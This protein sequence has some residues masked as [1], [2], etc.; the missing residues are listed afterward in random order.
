[1][2]VNKNALIRYKIL[3]RCF[4]NP[5]KRYFIEDLVEECNKQLMEIDPN[6]KGIQKRQLFEDIKYMESAEGWSAE[7]EKVAF[8]KKK[9]YRYADKNFSINNQPLNAA[10]IEQLHSA[11]D[12]ISR[13]KGMPQFEWINEFTPKLEQAFTLD[14]HV[15][16]IIS[17][18][19]NEYLKGV[20]Y[21][22][23]LFHA[24]L[25]KKVLHITYQPFTSGT[26]R[27]FVIHPYYLKQ[28]NN[29]WFLFGHNE[30]M[31]KLTNLALDRITLIEEQNSIYH[32]NDEYDFNEYF[33]DIIGV[34]KPDDGVVEKVILKFS[35]LSLPYILSKPLH[36]SQKSIR[37]EGEQ[38][39]SIEVMIN[40]E[41]ESLLLSFGDRVS[42]S[43][44]Q[45]LQDKIKM[46]LQ[47]AIEQYPTIKD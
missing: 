26:P 10:E 5:G 3:D 27:Y 8:G 28:Y 38:L 47:T 19:N 37:T 13:F 9:Y 23:E 7:I 17:F 39:I 31:E 1:M 4:S 45:H 21:I 29:R 6:S 40:Y 11:M 46:R 15:M 14:A 33:E 18:D 25:Y 32:E 20:E 30:Q 16:P 43:E 35:E 42:V 2:A 22:S 24:V 44:P 41:L 34:T 12:I 36:G